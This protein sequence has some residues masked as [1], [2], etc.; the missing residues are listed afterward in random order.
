MAI[1]VLS[2]LLILSI[3]L[4]IGAFYLGERKAGRF[5]RLLAINIIS[6]FGILLFMTAFMFSG[7][8]QAAS[9]TA[10]VAS[11]NAASALSAQGVG[12][13]SAALVTSV[14]TIATGLAV[15][16]A[17]SAAIGA[18]SENENI[19]GKALI[20]VAMCEGIAIY[21]IL[22]SVMILARL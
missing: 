14:A 1:K 11:P 18:L 5:K 3:V 12:F 2:V 21:G 8:V 16:K 7:I 13:F 20:F 22:I 19:M 9:T 4:P 10:A 17:A 6:F 15:G